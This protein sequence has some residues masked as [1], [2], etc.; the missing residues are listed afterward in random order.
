M[1]SSIKRKKVEGNLAQRILSLSPNRRW[2]K[3]ATRVKKVT[4]FQKCTATFDLGCVARGD[5]C[6]EH[7]ITEIF[8][9]II[10]RSLIREKPTRNKKV[11]GV[12]FRGGSLYG[13]LRRR[14]AGNSVRV[15]VFPVSR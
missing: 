15:A 14:E 13:F 11:R 7:Q 3:K 10:G 4:E 6:R 2:N 9:W 5:R 8:L 1:R 12:Q